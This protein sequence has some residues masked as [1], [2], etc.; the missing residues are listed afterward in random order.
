M[1]IDVF[2]IS[3]HDNMLLKVFIITCNL[4]KCALN[5]NWTTKV[6]LIFLTPLL[7]WFGFEYKFKIIQNYM[8][9]KMVFTWSKNLLWQDLAHQTNSTYWFTKLIILIGSP[10]QFYLMVQQTNSTYWVTKPILLIGSPN[11]FYLLVHQTNST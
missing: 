5:S 7:V 9:W 1:K 10:N 6:F 8:F 2:S 3:F 11:Y 4:Y